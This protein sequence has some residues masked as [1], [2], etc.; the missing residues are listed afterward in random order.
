MFTPFQTV[1]VEQ[2]LAS[3]SAFV[4]IV[5]ILSNVG[6]IF[7]AIDGVYAVIFG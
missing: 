5:N 6:G 3:Q 4:L 2:D 1:V 7:A